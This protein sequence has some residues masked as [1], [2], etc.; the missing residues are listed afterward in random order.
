MP[1]LSK[2]KWGGRVSAVMA[3]SGYLWRLAERPSK[4]LFHFRAELTT[5]GGGA[6]QFFFR[7]AV[8]PPLDNSLQPC[9][10]VFEFYLF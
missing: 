6:N 5:G 7:A 4:A 1:D 9:V 10:R 2:N 8:D 3:T